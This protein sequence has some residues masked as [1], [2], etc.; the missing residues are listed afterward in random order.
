MKNFK[1]KLARVFGLALRSDLEKVNEAYED[2]DKMRDHYLSDIM[3][4]TAPETSL[5]RQTELVSLYRFQREINHCLW[6]GGNVGFSRT[7][8]KC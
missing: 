7:K 8:D 1:R 4:I 2:V 6:M 5:S 3:T